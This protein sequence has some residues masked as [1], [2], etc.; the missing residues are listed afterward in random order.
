MPLE[1][2]YPGLNIAAIAPIIWLNVEYRMM[3]IGG[4][5]S[6]KFIQVG[7]TSIPLV[8]ILLIDR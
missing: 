2:L 8:K 6:G 5:Q 4:E 3:S 7:D 1:I